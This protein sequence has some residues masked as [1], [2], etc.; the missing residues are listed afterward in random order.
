MGSQDVHMCP[1]SFP[2][3]SLSGPPN[4]K[5]YWAKGV[6]TM[7]LPNRQE[8]WKFVDNEIIIIRSTGLASKPIILEPQSGVCFPGVFRDVGRRSVPWWEDNV[9]DVS[10][11][12][13]RSRQV[14][15]RAS[16]LAAVVA[17]ATTRVV[18]AAS[19]LPL[20][21]VGTPAGIQC[22]AGTPASI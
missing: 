17:S 8:Q 6:P 22:V 1:R 9:V 16:V 13:L 2:R 14:G 15:A 20:T 3:R 7:F 5:F 19:L 10:A 4:F 11:K 12:G 18:A 21:V